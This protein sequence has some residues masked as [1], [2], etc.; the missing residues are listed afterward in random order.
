MA[1]SRGWARR[2]CRPVRA[3]DPVRAFER[4]T[5]SVFSDPALEY[6]CLDG[7]RFRKHSGCA[8]RRCR[9]SLAKPVTALS[10]WDQFLPVILLARPMEP[11]AS[12]ELAPDR[13]GP[14]SALGTSFRAV[15]LLTRNRTT[16]VENGSLQLRTK[17]SV[18]SPWAS[19][20]RWPCAKRIRR[21]GEWPCATKS[22]PRPRNFRP[23]GPRLG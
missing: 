16:L 11:G 1:Q 4:L 12:R 3:F 5:T 13:S 9:R 2:R 14:G 17:L 23:V 8:H 22:T 10:D 21:R 15:R 20:R 19:G 6:L 18:R 7:P